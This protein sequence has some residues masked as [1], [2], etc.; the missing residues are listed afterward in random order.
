MRKDLNKVLTETYKE[1]PFGRGRS[2]RGVRTAFNREHDEVGGREGMR[3]A[4]RFKG[5]Y[6]KSFGENLA[7]LYRFVEKQVGRPWDKIYSDLNKVFDRRSVINNHIFEHIYDKI[8]KAKEIFYREGKPYL[9]GYSGS[10]PPL[11]GTYKPYYV[12]PRDGILKTIPGYKTRSQQK[13][14][15]QS[16]EKA[17]LD[18]V[19]VVI[20]K[21]NELWLIEGVWF[22]YILKTRPKPETRYLEPENW[23]NQEAWYIKDKCFQKKFILENGGTILLQKLTRYEQPFIFELENPIWKAMKKH[24]PAWVNHDTKEGSLYYA[25]KYTAS[26]RLLKKHGFTW[27]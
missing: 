5:A 23:E 1:G 7:P 10:M 13:K 19:K 14:D 11:S 6:T 18:K 2:F 3:C 27:G 21:F 22:H 20:D 12:D 15:R 8:V 25:E 4:F 26:K 17:E 9:I 16:K 24:P